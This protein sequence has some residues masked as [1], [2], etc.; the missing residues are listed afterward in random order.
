VEAGDPLLNRF[1]KTEHGIAEPPQRPGYP[2]SMRK[3]MIKETGDKYL[4]K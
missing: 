3:Q 1:K 2:E 4:M